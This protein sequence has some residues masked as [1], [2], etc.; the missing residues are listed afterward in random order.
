M[1]GS[2]SQLLSIAAHGNEFLTGHSMDGYF[3]HG[4]VFR[5]CKFVKFVDLESSGDERHE[6][7]YAGD[8]VAWFQKLEDSGVIQL[9]VH[10]IFTD[11]GD[12]SDRMSVAFVGGGGRWV[13][14][15]V[16][17]SKSDFWEAR[18]ELGDRDDPDQNIWHVTYGRILKNADQPEEALPA[19]GKV[20]IR[21]EELLR[22]ISSFA[23]N[24]DLANFGKCF[25]RGVKA[26]VEAPA[27]ND[28]ESG[29]FPEGYASFEQRRLL[30]ACQHAW[31]FGGMGSWNDIGFD[32]NETQVEY[33]ALSDELFDLMNLSLVVAC[34]PFSRPR[35]D[36]EN[37]HEEGPRNWWQFWR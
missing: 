17:L 30:D 15:A 28:T 18:W 36:R 10:R 12:V 32:N 16:K 8:P 4:L 2:I 34:N 24:N 23:H 11:G 25:D 14:E 22:K 33:E 1:Q 35:S 5:F 7:E 6:T 31:V 21:L 37:V 29:I 27:S 9:R 3:P 26:L 13:I 20:K 19:I